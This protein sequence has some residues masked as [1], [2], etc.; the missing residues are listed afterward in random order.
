MYG[1]LKWLHPG[2]SGSHCSNHGYLPSFSLGFSSLF[3][4]GGGVAYTLGR[5][6]V[7]GGASSNEP[8]IILPA[9]IT[10]YFLTLF[11]PIALNTGM[12][13]FVNSWGTV[14]LITNIFLFFTVTNMYG[15]IFLQFP[16]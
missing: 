9:I 2:T 11:D 10:M 8:T 15:E 1:F 12:C 7:V 5:M 16:T 3:L 14:F 4:K 13:K 6:G